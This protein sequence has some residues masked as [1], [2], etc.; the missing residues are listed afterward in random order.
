MIYSKSMKTRVTSKDN[1]LTYNTSK[2]VWLLSAEDIYIYDQLYLLF[3]KLYTFRCEAPSG[4][5]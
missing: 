4:N 3:T 1:D 5:I 2:F